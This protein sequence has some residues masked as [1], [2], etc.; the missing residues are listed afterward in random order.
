MNVIE[1]SGVKWGLSKVAILEY[2]R[3]QDQDQDR[4]PSLKILG[5]KTILNATVLR[6]SQSFPYILMLLKSQ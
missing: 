6:I 2:I 3:G 1:K 5:R 4:Y